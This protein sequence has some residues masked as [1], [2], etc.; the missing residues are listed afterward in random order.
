[1]SDYLYSYKNGNK[2]NPIV[3][4]FFVNVNIVLHDYEIGTFS[5]SLKIKM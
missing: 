5:V 3:I 1:M 4:V 2:N